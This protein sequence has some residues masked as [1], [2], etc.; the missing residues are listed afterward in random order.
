MS[1]KSD[2]TNSKPTGSQVHK[3]ELEI[4]NCASVVRVSSVNEIASV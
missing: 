1:C 3:V 4:R 2:V